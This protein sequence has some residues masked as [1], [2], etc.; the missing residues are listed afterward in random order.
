MPTLTSDLHAE[1]AEVVSGMIGH[2]GLGCLTKAGKG[3]GRDKRHSGDMCYVGA[4]HALFSRILGSPA[5]LVVDTGLLRGDRT[6]VELRIYIVY[7]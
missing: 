1:E 6:D 7:T 5:M 4:A 3:Q 2:P